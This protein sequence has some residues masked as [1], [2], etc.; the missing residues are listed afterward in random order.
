M[1]WG[2]S[3]GDWVG[4]G[5]HRGGVAEQNGGEMGARTGVGGEVRPPSSRPAAGLGAEEVGHAGLGDRKS[6]V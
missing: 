1:V 5:S 6:V 4:L 2:H 3:S